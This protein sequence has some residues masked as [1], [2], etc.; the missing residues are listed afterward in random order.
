MPRRVAAGAPQGAPLA[1]ASI[2]G[3][4]LQRAQRLP[5]PLP[6]PRW[7]P[8]REPVLAEADAAAGKHMHL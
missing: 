1:G 3:P 2:G 7:A 8:A 4:G 6:A 5:A